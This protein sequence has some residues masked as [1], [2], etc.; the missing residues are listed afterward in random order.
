MI[1][2]N[3]VNAPPNGIILRQSQNISI[4][5]DNAV[6]WESASPTPMLEANGLTAT[7]LGQIV[8]G[9]NKLAMETLRENFGECDRLIPAIPCLL[10]VTAMILIG[11]GAA[12]M[13]DSDGMPTGFIFGF[14]CF[15]AGGFGM[16][17][18][19]TYTVT[20]WGKAAETAVQKIT[21]YANTTL[22]EEW[23]G[24]HVRW[25]VVTQQVLVNGSSRVQTRTVYHITAAPTNQPAPQQM[26]MQQMP[27]QGGVQV[28]QMPMQQMQGVQGQQVVQYVA[29]PAAGQIP[30][31]VQVQYV[32]VPV[33]GQ[34]AGTVQPVSQAP[35]QYEAG[36]TETNGTQIVY[37]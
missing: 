31:G 6:S 13:G 36:G 29:A 37:N 18:S 11:T 25:E 35:P 8:Q 20:K 27:M 9:F 22:N 33:G 4:L 12:S 10:L 17:A 24:N 23:K 28:V 15:A 5:S 7:K 14:I 34:P 16:V 30:Q 26:V 21:E 32:T 2:V 1:G 3:Q 19:F